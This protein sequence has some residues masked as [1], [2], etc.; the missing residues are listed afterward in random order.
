MRKHLLIWRLWR[1]VNRVRV[2]HPIY[3][4]AQGHSYT[5]PHILEAGFV[6]TL[7]I[8][9][10]ISRE[11]ENDTYDLLAVTPDGA[12]GTGIMMSSGV[13]H[14]L[15]E[16][17]QYLGLLVWILRFVVLG[18][19]L[20]STV[21]RMDN[22]VTALLYWCSAAIP[23]VG[24]WALHHYDISLSVLIGVLVPAVTRDRNTTPIFAT[25]L[26]LFL[27]MLPAVQAVMGFQ[28]ALN[29]GGANYPLFLVL[30]V[31][32][33]AVMVALCEGVA[34]LLWHRL[35]LTLDVAPAEAATALDEALR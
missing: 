24:L 26:H 10:T 5:L 9:R 30:S 29:L 12:L 20:G 32:N 19:W 27:L 18:M 3:S 7:Y 6:W 1:A 4:H 33:I 8:A 22:A 15:I 13:M 2:W 35:L 14:R 21:I 11:Y 16:V 28:W 25:S 23:L 31:V 17:T 34:R